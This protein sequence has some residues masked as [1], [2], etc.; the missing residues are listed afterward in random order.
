MKLKK[1]L[2]GLVIN[3]V[4]RRRHQQRLLWTQLPR[5]TG[6]KRELE[7]RRN[8]RAKKWLTGILK[9]DC[10]KTLFNIE[11]VILGIP[12]LWHAPN[13][14]GGLCAPFH[15]LRDGLDVTDEW[16]DPGPRFKRC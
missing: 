1:R 9:D 5:E 12:K 15:I 16:G 3:S 2:A 6:R 8:G 11:S 13:P 7:Q 14:P 10:V 4:T